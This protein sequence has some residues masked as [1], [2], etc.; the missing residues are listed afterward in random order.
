MGVKVRGGFDLIQ[1]GLINTSG[2]IGLNFQDFEDQAIAAMI[3]DWSEKSNTRDT[4][5]SAHKRDLYADLVIY[6]LNS[7]RK[8][9]Y[10]IEAQTC[11]PENGNYGDQY[12]SDKSPLGKMSIQLKAEWMKKTLLNV[13]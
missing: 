9:I 11:L 6:R 7:F 5:R 10:Q 4:H 13:V 3:Q 8:K 2:T 1:P 12:T